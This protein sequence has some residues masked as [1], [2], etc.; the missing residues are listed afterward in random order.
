MSQTKHKLPEDLKSQC[1]SLVRG[2]NR[3][4]LL[5]HERRTD[6]VCDSPPPK[7]VT[8]K[9]KNG[10]E[11]GEFTGRTS[12]TSDPTCDK[13]IKLEKIET[14]PDTVAM[15]AV[16]QAKLMIGV[17]L[18][19]DARYMLTQAIWDSCMLGRNFSFAHYDLPLGNNNFYERRRRFLWQIAKN[20][21]FI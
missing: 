12:R 18:C 3:R 8:S 7:I 9:D 19:G 4:V 21:G 17:D 15:K 6:A 10:K 20:M 16:E 11:I 13:A 2:Y 1:L 5:Y 14:L